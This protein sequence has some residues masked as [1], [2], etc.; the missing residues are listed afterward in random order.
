MRKL[1]IVLIL[2]VLA[3]GCNPLSAIWGAVKPSGGVD[4]DAEMTIGDKEETVATDVSGEK[5]V[6]TAE[7]ITYNIHEENK[8]SLTLL[9][10]AILGWLAPSPRQ[11]YLMG[12]Q[13]VGFLR[14]GPQK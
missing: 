3:S 11:C 5:T 12:K 6:N 10:V 13:F 9:I 2:S 7:N 14:R 1:L 8:T 4:V